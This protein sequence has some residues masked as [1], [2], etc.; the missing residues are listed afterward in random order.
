MNVTLPQELDS[1]LPTQRSMKLKS[2]VQVTPL[3]H[4]MIMNNKNG[5]LEEISQNLFY[6]TIPET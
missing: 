5:D 2:T 4:T 1:I 3:N 6:I